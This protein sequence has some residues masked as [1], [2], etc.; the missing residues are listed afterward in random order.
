M[1]PILG[2]VLTSAASGLGGII[3]GERANR[4]NAKEASKNRQ[5]Q[6]RMSS[7]AH[8]REVADLR[9]AGLNPILS[10]GGSGASQPGGAQ[11]QMQNSLA[12]MNSDVLNSISTSSAVKKQSAETN[13]TQAQTAN[14]KEQKKIIDA[15]ADKTR[16]E[17]AMIRRKIPFAETETKF[18]KYIEG[19]L[20]KGASSAK[21]V[22]NDKKK[23]VIRQYQK[24]KQLE[25][26]RKAQ[27]KRDQQEAERLRKSLYRS[28]K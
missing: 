13:Y 22:I 23:T 26:E 28:Y 2:T 17:A 10:A 9:A 21:K 4:A 14:A 12:N 16:A 6:E 1:M 8:Q 24:G 18:L 11:A 27:K 25:A 3:G 20:V 19:Q 7:S 15:Q 5:F